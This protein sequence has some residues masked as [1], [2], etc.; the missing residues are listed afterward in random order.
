MGERSLTACCA[1]TADIAEP[2]VCHPAM[3]SLEKIEAANKPKPTAAA[4]EAKEKSRHSYLKLT[5]EQLNMMRDAFM[6]FDLDGSGSIET[7]E[8]QAVLA[9]MKINRTQDQIEEMIAEIDGDDKGAINFPEFVLM[10]ADRMAE[11]DKVIMEMRKALKAF[12]PDQT[13][14]IE[15]KKLVEVMSTMGDCMG[16][17]DTEE[18]MS[19]VGIFDGEVDYVAMLDLVG[20]GS[21]HETPEERYDSLD[22]NGDGVVDEEELLKAANA[23][24]NFNQAPPVEVQP[25]SEPDSDE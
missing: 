8:L 17:M 16:K 23:S 25:E 20:E 7:S 15:A 14:M 12:D 24:E 11:Q 4:L 13:G 19:L 3:T 6:M 9:S 18:M 1:R 10:M 21:S 22:I 5:D 2:T